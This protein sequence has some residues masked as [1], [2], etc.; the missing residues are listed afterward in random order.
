[1]LEKMV[2]K[3]QADGVVLCQMKFCDP[4]EFDY[5]L[6][7]ADLDKAGIPNLMIE[8]DLE[9][10]SFEQIRTRVQTFSDIFR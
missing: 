1:M 5:P 2:K 9:A 4:E 8:V 6:L 7:Y 10:R 3:Q